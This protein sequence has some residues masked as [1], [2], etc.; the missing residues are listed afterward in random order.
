MTKLT[1]GKLREMLDGVDD[2]M[3]V[4][5]WSDYWPGDAEIEGSG[6]QTGVH[7]SQD[8]TEYF[9]VNGF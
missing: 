7:D 8:D 6:V 1:V 2:N 3:I 5:G 4:V 9:V